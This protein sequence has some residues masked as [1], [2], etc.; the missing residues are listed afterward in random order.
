M[1]LKKFF[2]KI[3]RPEIFL[4]IFILLSC[5]T[6]SSLKGKIKGIEDVITQAEANG[7][8]VCAPVQLAMAKSHAEFAKL[9]LEEGYM[10]KAKKHVQIAEVN[11]QEAYDLSPP[12]KCAPKE[13][14]VEVPMIPK[15]GDRDGDGCPDN[16]D[17][18]PDE[19]EDYD[20]VE[21]DDCCPEDQDTDMDGIPDS[22]DICVVDPEDMDNYLDDDGCPDWDNDSDGIADNKDSCPNEPEDPD[23]WQDDDGCPDNDNDDDTIVDIDDECP[24][25]KGVPE[26]KGCPKKYTGVVITDKYLKILQKIFFEYNQAVIM[27]ESY[28]I[29]NEVVGVLKDRPEI[30]LEIQGHTDDKGSDNYNLCLSAA[31]AKSVMVYLM[32]H[33]IDQSRL[34]SA[35]YGETCPIASNKTKEGRAENRRVEFMRTDVPEPDRPCPVPPMPSKCKKFK[36]K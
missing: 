22:K 17:K 13:I 36:M 8:Y 25:V 4:M 24:N 21:D 9:E 14:R 28:P 15:V 32:E 35:G 1:K 34:T 7:A 12:E 26:E 5:T 18:C 19:P 20:G 3:L 2:K 23:G 10:S 29:L 11:A 6:A 16:V 27:P 30:T 33:G 31:R